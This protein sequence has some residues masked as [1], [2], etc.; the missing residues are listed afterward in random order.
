MKSP[1]P[2]CVVVGIL[3]AVLPAGAAAAKPAA[4]ADFY[5][6]PAGNDGW[7]G[8]FAEPRPD[9]SDG[10]YATIE[11]A[12]DAVRAAMATEPRD[13]RVLLRGGTYRLSRTI[14]FSLADS[15]GEHRICYEAFPGEK[16]VLSSGIPVAGWQKLTSPPPG[17]PEPAQGKV[18]VADVA[19]RGVFRTLFDGTE[20]LSRARSVGFSPVNITPRGSQDYNTVQFPVGAVAKSGNPGD[21]E[22]RIVPSHF[23]I[24][25]LLPVES[26]DEETSVM[27]TAFPGTYPLGKNGMTDR[28]SAWIEN[29]VEVLD[30]P[31]EW[32]LDR[33]KGRLYL[34]P[35][36]DTPG[37]GV[38]VPCLTELVRVEGQIDYEGPKDKPVRGIVFKGL[39]FMHGDRYPWHGRTGWGLQHDWECFD[40]PTGLLRFRGA[41]C[42][43]VEDCE[44]RSSGHT[45]IR[46]DLHCRENR[47]VGNRIHRVGGV[48]VLLAGYGPGTK[49]VNRNNTVAN[50]L[51]DH[52][53][54][55]YWGSAGIFAWQSGENRIVHNHLHHLPYTA[56]V[57][58]GRIS[59]TPPGPGECSRTIR[60]NEVPQEFAKWPWKQREPYLHS[61]KN[62]IELNEIHNAMERLGDGNCIYVS[63]AGGGNVVRRNFCHD[64]TGGY[65]NAVIRCD[66]DQHETLLEGNICCRTGGYGE[67]FISKGDNDIVNNVIADLRPVRGHRGYIVFPYGQITGSRI[68]KNIVYSRHA[69]Q[70]LYYHSKGSKGGAPPRLSDAQV[71]RNL[72]F[73]TED[74]HWADEL[75]KEQRAKG[76][77]IHSRQA[78]PE[79]R[80]VDG[81]D[82]RFGVDSPAAKMGIEPL[83]A[84]EMGL[85]PEYR[86]R[87]LGRAIRTRI[88]P[89]DQVLRKTLT[90]TITSSEPSARI[91]YTLDGSEPSAES[92]VYRGPFPLDHPCMVRARSF[93]SG[94]SDVVGVEVS[95]GA[96]PAPI[97]EDFEAIPVG[98]PS[99]LATTAE[100]GQLK[101]FTA[102]VTDENASEGRHCLRLSDGP[103]QKASYTPHVYYR[104]TY[105]E[106]DVVGQ[107]DVLV[108]SSSALSY[109]WRQY[110]TG[111]VTGPELLID[112]GGHVSS[113]G[114]AIASIPV[115]QWVR[116]EI[117]CGV[118]KESNGRFD[119][120]IWEAKDGEAK[121]FL[122]LP[123]SARFTRL[124]WVGFVCRA[125]TE[126][127][128]L[129]DEVEVRVE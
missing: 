68:E 77:D 49:D 56:I 57:A 121:A 39:T 99:A 96:P 40:K 45:A 14:V 52:I 84:R 124:D 75:L 51:I 119:L 33:S 126:A 4:K 72:Y 27:Q 41:E 42:C 105:H 43:E 9:G 8:Q 66:D 104:R 63:G 112:R 15:A 13:Y 80:D 35:T 118:G 117:R 64:C 23:W 103:G 120:R 109:Q 46:L 53:G 38:V 60:W 3:V 127:V 32:V 58:T 7:S 101:Q 70:L 12:R 6:S 28:D 20:Q 74:A 102:R 5:V 34:W 82:F 18:W 59:R 107:F 24:M 67:G 48:G 19:D 2:F 73:C 116:F 62:L 25:N 78:D 54:Q 30:E 113:G 36:K 94:A 89:P 65:M 87:F 93:A 114:K 55:E 17:L 21:V 29:A 81:N 108:D 44:F 11:R 71:D 110:D 115:G 100:D 76:S 125:Q 95:Y 83:D 88:E 79:F 69:G 16:P 26:V 1:L 91:F 97:V 22:L 50:N 85:E 86:Q 31:G 98:A 123:H 10:P 106:G 90:V 61:R 128:C 92:T 37:D 129:V 47:I 111:Y 122:G